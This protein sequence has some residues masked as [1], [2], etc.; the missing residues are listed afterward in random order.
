[1][2]IIFISILFITSC[3]LPSYSVVEAPIKTSTD[4]ETVLVSFAAPSN[5]SNISGYEVYYKIYP[6]SNETEIK[7]DREQFNISNSSYTF[8]FGSKKPLA[9]GFR[10][11]Q[12][13]ELSGNTLVPQ[14]V[15][16]AIPL[17]SN[18][19]TAP[20][21]LQENEE[22]EINFSSPDG[23]IKINGTTVWY[24]LRYIKDIDGNLKTF[25]SNS[26]DIEGD[27]DANGVESSTPYSIS[28]VAFSYVSAIIST[29]Q[30]SVPV[31]LGTISR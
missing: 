24:P 5:H 4:S 8:E 18:D 10:R 23:S 13:G 25:S 1:M 17:I 21:N 27:D 15:F 6:A 19:I 30:S 2:L 22:L 14:D 26:G 20:I 7:S 12:Y 16:L 11:L 29:Y 3:G 28:F 31:F 9:L